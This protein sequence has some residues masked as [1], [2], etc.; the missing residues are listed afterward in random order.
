[1]ESSSAVTG[2]SE[3]AMSASWARGV[4]LILR[5]AWTLRTAVENAGV[6]MSDA[7]VRSCAALTLEP[8]GALSVFAEDSAAM[9][10]SRARIRA[11]IASPGS[12][13]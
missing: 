2:A 8:A 9:D 6:L 5:S 4:S 11:F 12:S 1:M 10:S 13:S 3:S 7:S